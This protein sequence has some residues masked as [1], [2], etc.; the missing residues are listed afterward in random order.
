[1]ALFFVDSDVPTEPPPVSV[2]VPSAHAVPWPTA[3][4]SESASSTAKQYSRAERFLIFGPP[5]RLDVIGRSSCARHGIAPK[6]K[7]PGS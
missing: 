7:A 4:V 3:T 1:V 5:P 2:A 6:I